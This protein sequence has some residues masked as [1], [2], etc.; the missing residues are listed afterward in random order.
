VYDKSANRYLPIRRRVS[1]D[2]GLTWTEDELDF[3]DQPSHPAVLPDG[4]VVLAWVD[5][6]GTRSIR[7]RCAPSLDGD[8]DAATEVVLYQHPQPPASTTD[9]AA[10]LADMIQWTF[11]LPYAE[12]LPSGDV[13]VVYY[14]GS[15]QCMDVRWVR[16]AT[17]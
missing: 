6:Y 10:M 9:T 3:A 15:A 13:M 4:R 11:G 7:A 17:E 12:A 1:R 14:A 2:E 8:F 16:L 5:R